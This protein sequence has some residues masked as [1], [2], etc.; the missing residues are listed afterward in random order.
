M[1]IALAQINYHIGNF[2]KNTASIIQAIQNAK[3][4]RCELIVFAEL[5]VC[6]Y[7]PRDFLEF[8]DFIEQCIASVN[9]IA[10]ECVGIAAIV[11]FPSINSDEK[12]KNLFNSAAFLSEGKIQSLHHK[13]LLPNYDV[14]DEYRYFEPNKNSNIINFKG[15]KIALTICEDLWNIGEEQLYPYSPMDDLIAQHPDF[16]VNIA[17]SPFNYQQA[18][19]RKTVLIKNVEKYKIP[20][21]YVN[22]V[23]AQTELIFD[24]GSLAIN[25]NGDI[26][27]EMNY[28]EEDFS[29]INLNDL[30][31]PANNSITITKLNKIE[32]IHN[33]LVLGIKDY[34]GKLGFTKAILGLSGGIDSAVTL[35][36][37]AKALGNENV[38]AVL[39]PSHFSSQH[40]IDDA[41]KLA[42]NL[43]VP[44]ELIPIDEAYKSYENTLSSY[45]E[46]LPFDVTEENLQAR[47]RAVILMAFTNK[48][49][50]VLLNTSNKS[51]AAVGYGTLYGDM[52][53]GLAVIGD[54]YKT[55][56]YEL[57]HFINKNAEIIPNNSIIKPPSAELRPDQKDSDSL[58]D[59]G[60]LDQILYHYIEQRKG[61]RELIAMGFDGII[62]KKILKLVNTNEY[63]R[64]QTPPILR[65]SPKAFGMG[66]RMPIVG[67]YLA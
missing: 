19:C 21:L 62:V 37:S 28:F 61:P 2:E 45:F 55:E 31:L 33:A 58:P 56:V 3:T 47:I 50:Y 12:G 10:V 30:Q 17:A 4:Q 41:I 48:F 1:K 49:G 63:K 67:K 29:I 43:K 39:L 27:T 11:G 52:C 44:Y 14:F 57:A 20:L 18:E 26:V 34:F 36:L 54:L 5:A 9:K 59:Y 6:G 16:M 32:L 23:G 38:K 22:H 25:T 65:I 64:H 53:G 42:E 15:Y 8:T 66:R 7:P 51:E 60:I 46:G 35:V 13:S 40:S 24:G